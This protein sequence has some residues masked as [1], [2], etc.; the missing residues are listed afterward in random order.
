MRSVISI[1]LD[2]LLRVAGQ[3]CAENMVQLQRRVDE[4]V[5]AGKG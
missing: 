4:S 1:I 3:Q 2:F 5:K